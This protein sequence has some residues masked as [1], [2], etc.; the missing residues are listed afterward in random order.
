M[1]KK[2]VLATLIA[3]SFAAVPL[4]SIARTIIIREAPPP[5]RE[6]A[7]PAARRGYAWA[8]GHWVWRGNQHVWMEGHWMRARNNMHWVPE[9][10]VERNG[11]W[12]M[13]PGRWANGARGDRDG[14]GVPNRFDRAPNN[15]NKS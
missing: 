12:E 2:I 7:P 5:P 15:P 11:R 10:W 9:Q 4:T 13:R 6:E 3:S 1:L 8:P 14:D